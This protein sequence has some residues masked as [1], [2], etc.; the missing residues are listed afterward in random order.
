MVSI[1]FNMLEALWLIFC[2]VLGQN[3][4]L[5]NF[6]APWWPISYS[7]ESAIIANF[8]GL[9]LTYNLGHNRFSQVK[10]TDLL[11]LGTWPMDYFSIF[12]IS[13]ETVPLEWK[14]S[15]MRY[16]CDDL[17]FSWILYS[18]IC[19]K[20]IFR[21][22][23]S[24]ISMFKWVALKIFWHFLKFCLNSDNHN[25]LINDSTALLYGSLDR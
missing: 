21:W 4:N 23:L 13:F 24:E 8:E 10:F 18:C 14:L 12:H 1:L 5:P 7:F 11:I 20:K 17:T 3:M 22:I 25:F 9:H 16:T 2:H 19:E 15:K 6:G